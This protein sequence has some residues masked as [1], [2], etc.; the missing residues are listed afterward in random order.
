[1]KL[2]MQSGRF[3]LEL[4]AGNGGSKVVFFS[5][6]FA[7][8]ENGVELEVNVFAHLRKLSKNNLKA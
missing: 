5:L 3:M 6:L 7:R 1:M 4:G 8:N 2:K